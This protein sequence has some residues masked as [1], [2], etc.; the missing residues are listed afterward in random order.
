MSKSCHHNEKPSATSLFTIWSRPDKLQRCRRL[1]LEQAKLRQISENKS[2]GSLR[3][4]RFRAVSE[5][6]KTR[7][8]ILGFG[9]ARNETRAIFGVA[10]APKQHG[11]ACFAGS[12]EGGLIRKWFDR[13]YVAESLCNRLRGK[14]DHDLISQQ[15]ESWCGNQFYPYG[16]FAQYP[17]YPPGWID[18]YMLNDGGNVNHSPSASVT[19]AVSTR[20]LSAVHRKQL[21]T[22][23]SQ[24][25]VL[26]CSQILFS[27]ATV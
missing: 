11:N 12:S 3:S 17:Q 4:K 14:I 9:R 5:Q 19:N 1:P 22:R 8:E 24:H 21:N 6:R 26:F 16:E 18:P 2:E 15:H 13:W 25:G 10:F 23:R 20:I 27:S 7:N